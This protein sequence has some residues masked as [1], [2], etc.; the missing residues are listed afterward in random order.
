M[1]S[2]SEETLTRSLTTRLTPLQ[3]FVSQL[4]R[5]LSREK[6]PVENM[7]MELGTVRK[8]VSRECSYFNNPLVDEGLKRKRLN[9]LFVKDLLDGVNGTILDQKDR[10]DSEVVGQVSL[11]HKVL[12]WVFLFVSSF[13]MLYYVYLFAMRQS[14]SRQGAWL[15]SFQVWLLTEIFL[16]STGLVLVQHVLI[17]LWS[18]REVQRVKERIVS[19]ILTFQQKLR[20]AAKRQR[21]QFLATTASAASVTGVAVGGGREEMASEGEIGANEV[22]D[23]EYDPRSFNAAEFLY[24]SHRM[25]RLFRQYPESGLILQYKTLWPKKSFKHGEKSMKKKYDKRFE[26]VTKMFSQVGIFALTSVVQLPPALQDMGIQMVLLTVVGYLVK[27]HVRLFAI[28]PV[29][30]MFP[31]LLLGLL[32]Y[33]LV[34]SGRKV[35]TLYQTHPVNDEQEQVL[36]QEKDQEH[37]KEKDVETEKGEGRVRCGVVGEVHTRGLDAGQL[38]NVEEEKEKAPATAQDENQDEDEEV[39]VPSVSTRRVGDGSGVSL[40]RERQAYRD[41]LLAR[42]VMEGSSDSESYLDEFRP[43]LEAALNSMCSSDGSSSSSSSSSRSGMEGIYFRDLDRQ[44]EERFGGSGLECVES[45]TS[46]GFE[47]EGEGEWS[48]SSEELESTSSGSV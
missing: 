35:R 23:V 25:A 3:N 10:R 29:L 43:V 22:A 34:L 45:V 2:E 33:V 36:G 5:S 14:A 44:L 15:S 31:S 24:P 6:S 20:E 16:I 8:T 27:L 40:A 9:F 30:V 7:L 47:R 38:T 48:D 17:P 39:V 12:A 41:A 19:D 28:N 26:F 32:V 1:D 42:G 18:L 11:W 13:G 4:L 46:N 37:E 21:K